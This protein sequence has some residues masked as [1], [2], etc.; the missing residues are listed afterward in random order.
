MARISVF[1][2]GYVGAV[3]TA[4]LADHGHEV[5]GV[6]NNADKVATVAAGRSPVVEPGLPELVAR[7]VAA[8]RLRSTTDVGDAVASTD[9]SMIC[10]GTPSLGNGGLDLSQV[11]KVCHEIGAALAGTRKRHTVVV[12]STMLPGSTAEVVV[13]ALHGAMDAADAAQVAVCVNPEFLREGTSI[14]DFHAPPFTI[15]GADDAASAATV[16]SLYTM[17]PGE[18]VVVPVPVAEMLKYACNAFHALKVVFA[19]EL[20]SICQPQG[21][22]SARLMDVFVQDTRLNLS[23][24]YLKPGFAFGGSCLPK[25]L[26]ALVHHA[27][28]LDVDTPMLE[29]ILR[30]NRNHVDRT[31]RE[32]Q[33]TGHRRIGLVGLSFKPGTDDLRESPLVELAE[34]LIGKGYDLHVYDPGVAVGDLVG[35]NRTFIVHEI[36]HIA[37]LM[38]GSVEEFLAACDV[39]VVGHRSPEAATVLDQVDDHHVVI[40]VARTGLAPAPTVITLPEA[41]A[42]VT[43]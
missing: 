10:V 4:V 40:D 42:A 36:P 35:A 2:L 18:P 28:H 21:I 16:A 14:A 12:R 9:L 17:L 29:G 13:P 11:E 5:V 30:S 43:G 41:E 3:T 19:N 1:G 26:R 24:R 38:A 27:R 8:G 33:A 7:N 37:S 6:D 39:V 25:D 15:I 32:V 34:R 20:D 23:A 31:V 22:D